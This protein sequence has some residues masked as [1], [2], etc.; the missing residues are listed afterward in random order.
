MAGGVHDRRERFTATRVHSLD[1]AE[2]VRAFDA[3]TEL[4]VAEIDDEELASTVR[5]LVR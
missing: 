4:L 5:A 1:P 3:T 2:L